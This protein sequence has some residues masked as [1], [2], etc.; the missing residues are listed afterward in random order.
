LAITHKVSP[1][2]KKYG[3]IRLSKKVQHETP[4]FFL[5]GEFTVIA[6]GKRLEKMSLDKYGRMF[7][8]KPLKSK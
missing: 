1:S 3:F 8:G 7:I 2:E 6:F 4:E 5:K